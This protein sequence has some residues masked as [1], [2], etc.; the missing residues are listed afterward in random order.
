VVGILLS[1]ISSWSLGEG[2]N[3]CNGC[4]CGPLA[5]GYAFG[6]IT[7]ASASKDRV[8]GT[9]LPGTMSNVYTIRMV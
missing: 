4:D 9:M 7:F 8:G 2:D 1:K 6:T 3:T 5:G